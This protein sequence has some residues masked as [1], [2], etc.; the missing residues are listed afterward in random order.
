MDLFMDN[1]GSVYCCGLRQVEGEWSYV[2]IH[3]SKGRKTKA[4]I[5]S[6]VT[7]PRKMHHYEIGG[8]VFCA[9]TLYCHDM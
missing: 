3:F 7:T 8:S 5:D 1:K 2:R 4:M 6:C 9:L